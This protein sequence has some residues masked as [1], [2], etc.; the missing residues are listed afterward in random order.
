MTEVGVLMMRE[1]YANTW[2]TSKHDRS[3]NPEPKNWHTMVRGHIMD[4][5]P[6]SVRVVLQLPKTR[7]DPQSYTRRVNTDE[8]LDQVLADIW[9]PG[10]QWRRDAQG[11]P[12]QL[13][14]LDLKPVARGWLEFIQ[15]SLRVTTLTLQLKEQ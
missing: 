13:G 1:F 5:I 6:K 7:N 3:V 12:Y 8:R 11:K 2:V 14:R 10:A 4:F 9:V 15:R